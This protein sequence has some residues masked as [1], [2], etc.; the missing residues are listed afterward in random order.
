M[1]I[2]F[3][4]CTVVAAASD[5]TTSGKHNT[6]NAATTLLRK[7]YVTI[8]PRHKNYQQRI[9]CL[10]F[11]RDHVTDA[12]Q[13]PLASASI[14][15]ASNLQLIQA[16]EAT[17]QPQSA[18][19]STYT[20]GLPSAARLHDEISDAKGLCSGWNARATESHTG[21]PGTEVPG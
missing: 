15:G 11:Y 9:R 8:R 6:R 7:Q 5:N 10:L 19:S 17:A 21:E 1:K 4:R 14:S 3:G 13:P 20:R 16:V 12:K 18:P 2:T